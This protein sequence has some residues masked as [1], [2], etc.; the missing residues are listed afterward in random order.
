MKKLTFIS[1]LFLNLF[2]TCSYAQDNPNFAQGQYDLNVGIGLGATLGVGGGLP[3]SA[4]LD[5][6]INDQI[7][8][9][10]YFGFINFPESNFSY[11]I[12]GGRAAYHYPLIDNMDTYGGFMIGFNRT[13]VV[14]GRGGGLVPAGFIGGRYLFSDAFAGFAELGYGISYLTIG[15][16]YAW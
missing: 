13:T 6:G 12:F 9:G 4:S 2:I 1:I 8:I 16:N 15:V 5:F 10:G 14:G 11:S 3:I 7:S